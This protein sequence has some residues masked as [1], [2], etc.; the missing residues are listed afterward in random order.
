MPNLRDFYEAEEYRDNLAKKDMKNEI[1]RK[2]QLIE[3]P[4]SQ[5]CCYQVPQK[6]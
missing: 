2:K 5:W 1:G 3:V 6:V 4:I